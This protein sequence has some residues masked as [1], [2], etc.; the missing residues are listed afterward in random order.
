MHPLT[1]SDE[2]IARGCLPPPEFSR[3]V[4]TASLSKKPQT[5]TL[6]ATESECAALADRFKV[7]ALLSF[8]VEASL[9]KKRKDVVQCRGRLRQ[10]GAS[11]ASTKK[12][13]VVVI[14]LRPRRGRSYM[15]RFML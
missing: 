4:S 13:R 7:P 10:W 6:E 5:Q 14:N 1:H 12:S 9:R 11:S 15:M 2:R 8:T 3:L